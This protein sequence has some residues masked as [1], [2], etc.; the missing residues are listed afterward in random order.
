MLVLDPDQPQ[1]ASAASARAGPSTGAGAAAI[2]VPLQAVP[3][4]GRLRGALRRHIDDD[5]PGAL[6][7][8]FAAAAPLVAA[9]LEPA[10]PATR[11][12]LEQL[13]ALAQALP[14]LGELLSCAADEAERSVR[15]GVAGLWRSLGLR[16]AA[17]RWTVAEWEAAR[18]V[19]ACACAP[20]GSGDAERIRSG[21]RALAAGRFALAL[22]A[23]LAASEHAWTVAL[24]DR[25]ESVRHRCAHRTL[26]RSHGLSE[27]VR[28]D[29]ACAEALTVRLERWIAAGGSA[30]SLPGELEA[31]LV[32]ARTPARFA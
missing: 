25:Y 22:R 20:G 3:Y 10:A 18:M 11:P 29:P 16:V 1:I 7:A 12:D 5:V 28:T 27:L 13:R 14:E 26:W 9:L 31:A 4:L 17:P 24:A 2:Q 19:F 32:H 21:L 8:A 6:E 23:E 30:A 15:T